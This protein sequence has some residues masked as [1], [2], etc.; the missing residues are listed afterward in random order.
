M[1]CKICLL[2]GIIIAV[3]E[4]FIMIGLD[5]TNNYYHQEQVFLYM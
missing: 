4:N 2:Q 1:I 3:S 5:S